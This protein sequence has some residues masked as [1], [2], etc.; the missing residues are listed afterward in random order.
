M[1]EKRIFIGMGSNL[2]NSTA[3]LLQAWEMIG[4]DQD[5]EC[6][7]L[8]SPYVTAPVD[9]HSQH[10]FTN[11]VGELATSLEPMVLLKRLLEYETVLGR[12]RTEH[13]FGYEDRDID[14][15]V[16]YF[17][18]LESDD[19]DLVL[20][21]PHLYDRLFVLTPLAEIAPDFVDCKRGKTIKELETRLRQRIND[22]VERDQDI[23]RSSWEH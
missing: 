17:G 19:P 2:G 23:N 8:S 11:A 13:S 7:K 16:L 15:D 10:W 14:L 1:A 20:P 22:G 3:K 18:D 6:V 5:I 4:E 21:H 9:M 12:V